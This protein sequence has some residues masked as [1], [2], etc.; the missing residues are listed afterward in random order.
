RSFI[1][2]RYNSCGRRRFYAQLQQ[3]FHEKITIPAS[4][5]KSIW[6]YAHLLPEV[7]SSYHL[8]IGEGDTPLV[9]SRNIGPSLGIK[10]LYFKLENLNPSGSYKDRF[11][12][13]ALSQIQER[14]VGFCLAT[15][16]GNTGAALAA[17]SAVPRI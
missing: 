1:Y 7:S 5:L 17:Y 10:N 6:K 13:M 14:G 16:S 3:L 9:R 15:S 4:V 2:D 8:S 11:A 12:A